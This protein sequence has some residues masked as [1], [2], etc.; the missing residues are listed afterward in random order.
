[1]FAV[2]SAHRLLLLLLELRMVRFDGSVS[3]LLE[4]TVL[5]GGFLAEIHG[6]KIKIDFSDEVALWFVLVLM[7]VQFSGIFDLLHKEIGA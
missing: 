1:M 7:L 6:H 4:A 5:R 2:L 3:P